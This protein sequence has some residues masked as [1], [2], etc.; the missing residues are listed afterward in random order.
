MLWMLVRP[1]AAHH[2]CGE[3]TIQRGSNGRGW[4]RSCLRRCG[5]AIPTQEV[6]HARLR[7]TR[8]HAALRGSLLSH[9]FPTAGTF[10]YFCEVH[11]A[12]M[13]GTVIVQ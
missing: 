1:I 8:D 13:T 10:P 11:G 7:I 3:R 9:T 4:R 2:P 12:M 5:D 6:A